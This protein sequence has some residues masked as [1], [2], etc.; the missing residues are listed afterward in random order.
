MRRRRKRIYWPSLTTKEKIRA[1][2]R[3]LAFKRNRN[4]TG[5]DIRRDSGLFPRRNKIGSRH[6]LLAAWAKFAERQGPAAEID[7]ARRQV[8]PFR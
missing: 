6:P 5:E 7:L 1:L 2:Q 3:I 4:A 8:V